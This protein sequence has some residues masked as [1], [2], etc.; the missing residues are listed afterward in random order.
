MMISAI[1]FSWLTYLYFPISYD[2]QL[3]HPGLFKA[4]VMAVSGLRLFMLF[5]AVKGRYV[6]KA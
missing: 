2:L 6:R 5:L 3:A 1:L 4:V